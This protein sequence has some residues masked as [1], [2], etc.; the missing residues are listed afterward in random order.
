MEYDISMGA[1]KTL[2]TFEEFEQMDHPAGKSE[3]LEGELFQL[4]PAKNKHNEAAESL[5]LMLRR[6]FK[7]MHRRGVETPAGRPRFELGYILG[8]EPATWLQPD[9]SI[10]WAAQSDEGYLEGAPMFAFEILSKSNRPAYIARKCA[11]YLQFGAAEVWA[12]DPQAHFAVVHTKSGK[13]R[14]EEA[15]RSELLPGL[16]IPFADFL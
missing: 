5:F 3:L 7:A 1:I 2:L 12:I 16:E 6:E 8:H 14:E 11:K 13:R 4:P 10:T 9:V 15:V